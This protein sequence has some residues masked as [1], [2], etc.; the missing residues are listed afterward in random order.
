M[1]KVVGQKI[2]LINNTNDSVERARTSW[3]CLSERSA[4]E[5]NVDM[6]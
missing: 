4:N 2:E 6:Q 1:Q 3:S 5:K